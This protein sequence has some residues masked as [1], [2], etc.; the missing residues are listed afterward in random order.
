MTWSPTWIWPINKETDNA[1]KDRKRG[2]SAVLN[3]APC[4]KKLIDQAVG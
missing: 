2:D 3:F 4:E 1:Y